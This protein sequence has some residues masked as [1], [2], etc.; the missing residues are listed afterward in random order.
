MISFMISLVQF[1][2]LLA[3]GAAGLGVVAGNCQRALHRRD[4]RDRYDH[5]FIGQFVHQLREAA[6]LDAT[7]QRICTELDV[8]EI[9]LAGIEPLLAHL[10]QMANDLEALRGNV[11]QHQRNAPDA[12]IVVGLD[13]DDDQPRVANVG[14]ERLAAADDIAVIDPPRPG[15]DGFEVRSRMRLGHGDRADQPARQQRGK[16]FRAL[17][18]RAVM[19]DVI[20]DDRLV[21][22]PPGSVVLTR[23]RLKNGCEGAK[24]TAGAAML[25]RNVGADEAEFAGLQPD[26]GVNPAPLRP[27]FLERR[28]LPGDECLG[29]LPDLT[30]KCHVDS[31]SL[32]SSYRPSM[33]ARFTKSINKLAYHTLCNH[34]R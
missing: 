13:R 30:R 18:I 14:D 29:D 17:P 11:D 8:G 31:S 27:F 3:E 4:R 2:Q 22:Y 20:Y 26:F 25:F 16:I 34:N 24:I 15:G 7:K 1:D 23:P 5:A 19:K 28:D 12:G 33:N 6:T 32:D 21:G 10:G 9:D